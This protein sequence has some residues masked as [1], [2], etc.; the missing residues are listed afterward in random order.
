[1]GNAV[2]S[3]DRCAR[4]RGDPGKRRDRDPR[5]S[6]HLS[7][8][9]VERGAGG[10]ERQ[11]RRLPARERRLDSWRIRRLRR[12]RSEPSRCRRA[13]HRADGRDRR[14]GNAQRQLLLGA[15]RIGVHEQR[16]A[17]RPDHSRRIRGR[18][19]SGRRRL[20]ALRRR[21][22]HAQRLPDARRMHA[23]EQL[24]DR[25][26]RCRLCPRRADRERLHVHGERGHDR[27]GRCDLRRHDRRRLRDRHGLRRQL[28]EG[29][30]RSRVR[31][32]QDGDVPRMHVHE[33]RRD[34]SRRL[35]RLVQLRWRDLGRSGE[36][37]PHRGTEHVRGE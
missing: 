26:R 24:V 8:R 25:L 19:R 23:D 16:H 6:R 20:Q 37:H 9:S 17:R 32:R 7:H 36:H 14:R 11:Q 35:L 28:G 21:R 3:S 30:G 27:Y 13:A 2:S 22:L 1:V 10:I 12:G 33:Q 18:L 4:L 15:A 31:L 5:R 34:R 29:S